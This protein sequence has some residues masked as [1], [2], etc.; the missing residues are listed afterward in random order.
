[1]LNNVC[2]DQDG[3]GKVTEQNRSNHTDYR[4]Q[5]FL[6][7]LVQSNK[8]GRRSYKHRDSMFQ[9]PKNKIK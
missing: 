4:R 6:G 5:S 1:V 2:F 8:S 3:E 7:D 9:F